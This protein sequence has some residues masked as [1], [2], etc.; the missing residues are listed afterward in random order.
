M[1]PETDKI[2]VDLWLGGDFP[3]WHPTPRPI[4]QL[5]IDRQGRLTMDGAAIADRTE[6]RRLIDAEQM[7]N[8]I[9]DLQVEP[10]PQA[11]YEDFI[12]V[13]LVIKQAHVYR[14]CIDW[15]PPEHRADLLASAKKQCPIAPPRL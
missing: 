10:D 1:P 6:L 13:L 4:H 8:Q 7:Q 11:R 12:K 3:W 14:V 2:M 9:P 15:D 5:V